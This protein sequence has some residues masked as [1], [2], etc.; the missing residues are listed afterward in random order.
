MICGEIKH[1]YAYNIK[2]RFSGFKP[3]NL[4][5]VRLQRQQDQNY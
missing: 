3:E 4:S 1:K 2:L 5:F